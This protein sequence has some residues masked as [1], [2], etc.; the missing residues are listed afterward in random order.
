MKTVGAFDFFFFLRLDA[1]SCGGHWE[2]RECQDK[3]Y[4]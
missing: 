1:E 4:Q 2:E 3:D